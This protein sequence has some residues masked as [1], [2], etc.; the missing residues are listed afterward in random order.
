MIFKGERLMELGPSR[1]AFITGGANGIGRGTARQ[2]ARRGVRVVSFDT[3][4]EGSRSL[5]WEIPLAC[6]LVCDCGDRAQ[7][8]RAFADAMARF[9]RVD[10]LVN[11]VGSFVESSFLEDAY[12]RAMDNLE[13]TL[14]VCLMSAYAFTQLAAPVMAKQGEGAVINVLTNHV[15]RDVCRV[16]P[17]EHAYDAAKYAQLS[18]N[19]S[20]A[21]ELGP[22]GIR[23]NAVD[24]AST[25]TKMLRDFFAARG[26]ELSAEAIGRMT[27]TPSLLTEDEVG[28]AICHLVQWEDPA[29]EGRNYLLRF[30][31]DC[32]NLN[33]QGRDGHVY[34]GTAQ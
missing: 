32:E 22:R 29:P 23:V 21:A 27:G 18:L 28:T 13:Q 11:N 10:I 2:L 12:E 3:D 19:M 25:A 30:R 33:R 6:G 24:P 7:A 5:E 31:E 20:M 14:R 16:S 8:A 1:V 9:G 17:R 4:E 15:H 26:L 34:P